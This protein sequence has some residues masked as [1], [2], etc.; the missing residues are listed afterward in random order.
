MGRDDVAKCVEDL[1]WPSHCHRGCDFEEVIGHQNIRY[2]SYGRHAL[3]DGLL[4]IGLKKGDR[5]LIPAYI[6]RDLLSAIH[7]M[8]AVPLYYDVDRELRLTT[9]VESLPQAEAVLAVNY[10]GFPAN[11]TPFKKYCQRTGAILVEDNAHG[12]FSRDEEGCLLGTRGDIGIFS[13]RKTV[14]IPNGAAMVLNAKKEAF[15]LRPQ[16]NFSMGT[17][18]LSFTIKKIFAALSPVLGLKTL[19]WIVRLGRRVRELRTGYKISPSRPEAEF[20]LPPDASPCKELANSLTKLDSAYE[21]YRRRELYALVDAI[22]KNAGYQPVFSSLP[23]HVVPYAYPFYSTE[24]RIEHVKKILAKIHLE[25]HPWPDLPDAI[26]HD[27]LEH[28]KTTWRVDFLW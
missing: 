21:I 4:I 19:R 8:G 20:S 22:V 6:C 28:Y 3:A 26:A 27:A 5:I 10:F 16:L 15:L 23:D 11:L 1:F 7:S 13:M 14:M 2:F 17:A 12:L 18:P 24:D 9:E 25:C